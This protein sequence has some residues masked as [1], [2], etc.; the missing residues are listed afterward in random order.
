MELFV[1]VAKEM[2]AFCNLKL[3]FCLCKPRVLQKGRPCECWLAAFYFPLQ[4][5]APRRPASSAQGCGSPR[6]PLFTCGS[7]RVQCASHRGRLA[8]SAPRDLGRRGRVLRGGR[9]SPALD[10]HNALLGSHAAHAREGVCVTPLH[11][12]SIQGTTLA[13]TT[14]LPVPFHR[15]EPSG[16]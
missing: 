6:M 2:A 12:S 10:A 15:R 7:S 16:P 3:Q 11:T 14:I 5:I 9:Q 4:P 1:P 13:A 8:G